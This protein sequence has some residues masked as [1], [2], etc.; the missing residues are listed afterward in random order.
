MR[1]LILETANGIANQSQVHDQHKRLSLPRDTNS[2]DNTGAAAPVFSILLVSP[3]RLVLV[4]HLTL[5][6]YAMK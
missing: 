6:G 3:G 1:I 5:I 2:I 4:M